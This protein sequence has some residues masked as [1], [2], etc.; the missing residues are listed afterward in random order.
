MSK[1]YQGIIKAVDSLLFE[2]HHPFRNREVV[3][4]E[5]RSFSLKNL[6]TYSR[7]SQGPEA[8]RVLL[9]TFFNV[10]SEAP[11]EN[12]ISCSHYCISPGQKLR[13]RLQA[14]AGL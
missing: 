12:D 7:S 1:D 9:D 13:C 11:K 3:I 14:T 4:G 2:L 8:I 10:I 6:A 5:L